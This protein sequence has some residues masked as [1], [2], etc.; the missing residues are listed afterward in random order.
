MNWLSAAE[1]QEAGLGIPGTGRWH[2]LK[3]AKMDT[4]L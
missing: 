4:T 2:L 3:S 1:E